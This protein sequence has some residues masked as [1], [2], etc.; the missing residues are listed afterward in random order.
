[1]YIRRMLYKCWFNSTIYDMY[2]AS[3][4][5]LFIVSHVTF[6]ASE[7]DCQLYIHEVDYIF[8]RLIIYSWG[9][10]YIREANFILYSWG[11]LYNSRGQLYIYSWGS[12]YYIQ[13]ANYIFMRLVIY[14]REW[15][16]IQE[17]NYSFM[18][19]IYIYIHNGFFS[20]VIMNEWYSIR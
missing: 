8:E 2:V 9:W 1:M 16:Y 3:T 11:S 12:L 7:S 4:V 18:R 15:L 17:V 6:H 10:L 14:S 13:E 20:L 19:P 5:L